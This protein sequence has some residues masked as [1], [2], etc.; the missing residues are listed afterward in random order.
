MLGIVSF[1]TSASFIAGFLV[2]RHIEIK[3]DNRFFRS[4]RTELDHRSRFIFNFVSRKLPL[5]LAQI[6]HYVI[7]H[8]TH[9][10]SSV[11]LRGIRAFEKRLHGFVNVVKGRKEV[12]LQEPSSFFKNVA[13]HKE[14]A[15][16]NPSERTFVR[17]DDEVGQMRG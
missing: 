10:S 16:L 9:L 11:L 5:L 14:Q 4:A 8:F 7:M 13:D 2:L 3:R 15:R 12:K 17:A 6:T 1:F